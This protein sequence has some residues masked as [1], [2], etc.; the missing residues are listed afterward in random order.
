M[1]IV[2]ILID[3]EIVKIIRD[4]VSIGKNKFQDKIIFIY[5]NRYCTYFYLP[6]K[7]N[8]LYRNPICKTM[9]CMYIF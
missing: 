9:L 8:Y 3:I 7:P 2:N 1:N 6:L 4:H 5:F